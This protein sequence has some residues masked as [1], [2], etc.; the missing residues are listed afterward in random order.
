MIDRGPWPVLPELSGSHRHSGQSSEQADSEQA[1]EHLGVNTLEQDAEYYQR[2]AEQ[3]AETARNASNSDVA[4][5]HLQLWEMFALRAA[6][7]RIEA[8][9]ADPPDP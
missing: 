9:E 6:R 8:G 5:A 3:E 7:L 2:R 4:A 1:E